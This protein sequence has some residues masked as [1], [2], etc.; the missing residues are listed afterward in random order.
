MSG[1]G[2]ML[3]FFN[4]HAVDLLRERAAA[5]VPWRHHEDIQSLPF[6]DKKKI[7]NQCS[8]FATK[9]FVPPF[10]QDG[11]LSVCI[12]IRLLSSSFYEVTWQRVRCISCWMSDLKKNKKI[13]I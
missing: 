11:Q 7:A 10:V 8:A 4:D 2:Y 5:S 6:K 1:A 12:S 9:I 3:F 13:K